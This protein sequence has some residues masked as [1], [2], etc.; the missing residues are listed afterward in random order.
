M[1]ATGHEAFAIELAQDLEAAK[2]GRAERVL[3]LEFYVHGAI[4]KSLERD[5]YKA[6]ITAA[7]KTTVDAVQK[8]RGVP[9][10]KYDA[11]FAAQLAGKVMK[12]LGDELF[13]GTFPVLD[14]AIAT[15]YMSAKKAVQK[16]H[17]GIYKDLGLELKHVTP[18]EAMIGSARKAAGGLSD[19]M[20]VRYPDFTLPDWRAINILR[21]Q[22]EVFVL[23]Y[24]QA[25]KDEILQFI[26]ESVLQSGVTPDE[27]GQRLQEKF[28]KLFEDGPAMA[29][30]APAQYF[31]GLAQHIVS[32]ARVTAMVQTFAQI[33]ITSYRW[34]SMLDRAVCETCSYLEGKVWYTQQAMDTVENVLTAGSSEAAIGAH[35]WLTKD[36]IVNATGITAAGYAGDPMAALDQ[37]QKLSALGVTHPPIHFRCRCTL[38]MDERLS[39]AEAPLPGRPQLPGGE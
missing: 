10:G 33:G 9:V 11:V 31:E 37:S 27:A 24:G 35:P 15:T 16:R 26:D 6:W 36:Q 29:R 2:Q 28:G 30:L 5:L 20:D 18:S 4:E 14:S 1:T 39:P 22:Q 32:T 38:D 12:T 21:Q 23:R 13:V 7:T 3:K 8:V 17:K 19:Y 25:Y 34:V